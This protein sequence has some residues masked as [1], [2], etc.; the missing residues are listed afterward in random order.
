MLV[1]RFWISCWRGLFG[2]GCILLMCIDSHGS[3]GIGTIQP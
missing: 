2:C 1:V 3:V